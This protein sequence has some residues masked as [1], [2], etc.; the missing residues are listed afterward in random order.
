VEQFQTPPLSACLSD[1]AQHTLK[2]K[3]LTKP[4]LEKKSLTDPKKI[5]DMATLNMESPSFDEYSNFFQI[6]LKSS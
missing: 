6:Y 1:S 2:R 3:R 4:T 5:N